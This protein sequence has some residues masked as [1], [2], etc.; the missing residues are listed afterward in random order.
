MKPAS[1]ALILFAAATVPAWADG[2]ALVLDGGQLYPATGAA[3]GGSRLGHGDVY[4]GAVGW[5]WDSGW[6][7]DLDYQDARGIRLTDHGAGLD[8]G[9]ADEQ[10]ATVNGS[11]ALGASGRLRPYVLLGLGQVRLQA[12]PV[13]TD[14]SSI[15]SVGL[16]GAVA[17]TPAW[18]LQAEVRD[19]RTFGAS[20]RNDLL[21]L[22]GVRVDFGDPPEVQEPEPAPM[23]TPVP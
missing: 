12:E 9:K 7:L 1:L 14:T 17:L 4:G 13:R 8:L 18:S 6:G 10:A 19:L 22:L 21:A 23:P 3:G 15:G 11:Y 5:R 20:S 16:G 2:P